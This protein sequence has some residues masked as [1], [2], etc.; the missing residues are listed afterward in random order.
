MLRHLQSYSWGTE[1]SKILNTSCIK[2]ICIGHDS[3]DA[4]SDR[5]FDMLRSKPSSL[6]YLINQKRLQCKVGMQCLNVQVFRLCPRWNI[7]ENNKMQELITRI[8]SETPCQLA[9]FLGS[10]HLSYCT[11]MI[12]RSLKIYVQSKLCQSYIKN[13]E[14]SNSGQN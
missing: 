8:V 1:H 12:T 9:V 10:K 13:S 14:F 5:F 4:L 7:L 6:L 2:L 3:W 11:N